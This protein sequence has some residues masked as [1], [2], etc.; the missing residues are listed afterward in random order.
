MQQSSALEAQRMIPYFCVALGS[1]LGGVARYGF[2][3]MAER[4]WG[5]SFPWGTIAVNI[6]GSFVIGFF[7]ALTVPEGAFPTSPNLRI[8]VMVGVCGGFTTFSSFSLQTLDLARDGSWFSAS[9]NVLLSVTFCLLAVTLGHYSG[10]RINI[11]RTEASPISH[12]ILAILDRPQT[13]H[14]V[15]AAAALTAKRTG[16]A[17][18]EAL[19]LRHDALEGFLPTEVM[20][21][22]RELEL[23][24]A[25]TRKSA[26]MHDLFNTWHEQAGTGDWKEVVGETKNVV[27][28]EATNADFV[29]IG[30]GAGRYQ[31]DARQAIHA[32]MFDAKRATIIVPEAI[33][34]SLGRSIAVAWKPS[35][36]A[37][38]AINAAMPLL[39]RAEQVNIL[40]ETDDGD[41]EAEPVSGLKRLKQAGVPVTMLRFQANGR[42]IGDALIDEAHNVGA[43]LLVMGAY[44][45]DRFAEF[46]LGGAIREVLATADLPVLMHH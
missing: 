28:A 37:D 42:K 16:N 33:P 18:I 10:E 31:G 40:V 23:E 41:E 14:S 2:G 7:G 39:M 17:S 27:T 36:A 46:I 43:D 6:I 24:D 13:A 9:G 15:L 3:L 32:A 21:K 12:N 22:Q 38:R 19:H 20:T 25:A 45:H 30:Q 1:A 34:T 44:T 4:L 8:L 35:A 29:V 5:E 26:E 11:L